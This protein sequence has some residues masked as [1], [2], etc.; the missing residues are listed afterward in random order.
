MLRQLFLL[1]IKTSLVDVVFSPQNAKF[2]GRSVPALKAS[3]HKSR[4]RFTRH[5]PSKRLPF[6]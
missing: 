1:F 2:L 5:Q 6:L 3:G 4:P